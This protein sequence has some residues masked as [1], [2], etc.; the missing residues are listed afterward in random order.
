MLQ[1]ELTEILEAE[2]AGAKRLSAKIADLAQQKQM[3]ERQLYEDF[4]VQKS[5][6]LA[7]QRREIDAMRVQMEQDLQ[8]K[9]ETQQSLLSQEALLLDAKKGEVVSLLVETFWTTP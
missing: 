4:R 3:L 5:T 8:Q 2:Q 1:S 9:I 7:Q 6:L